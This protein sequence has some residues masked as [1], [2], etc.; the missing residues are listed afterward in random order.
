[1]DRKGSRGTAVMMGQRKNS[2]WLDDGLKPKRNNDEV[3]GEREYGL[4]NCP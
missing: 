2:D 3:M 4:R 1:M